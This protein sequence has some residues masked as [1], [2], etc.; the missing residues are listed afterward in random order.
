MSLITLA[1]KHG[2]TADQAQ[3]SLRAAVGDV[4]T[5]FGPM[6]ER[7]QWATDGRGVEVIG[8]GFDIQMKVDD[9][10]V[11]VAGNIA[12]LGKLL[13]TPLMTGIKGILQNTFQKR[14]R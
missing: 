14:L 9:Q 8:R 1:I 5:R 13:G 12:L 10:D 6:I 7:V 4:S 11:H 3:Q 2:Q